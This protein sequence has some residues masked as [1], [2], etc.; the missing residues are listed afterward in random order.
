[1]VRGC[2]HSFYVVFW[3]SRCLDCR[4]VVIWIC[5]LCEKYRTL[6]N[7]DL[8]WASRWAEVSKIGFWRPS[9]TD[10][11]PYMLPILTFDFLASRG[12]RSSLGSLLA[13]LGGVD[14]CILQHLV[15]PCA[16]DHCI[17]QHLVDPSALDHCILQHLV[18]PSLRASHLLLRLSLSVGDP[19]RWFVGVDVRFTS[20]SGGR[21]VST[22]EL[23]SCGFCSVQPS[24]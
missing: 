13:W 8:P 3:R 5:P 18:D 4:T 6:S 22:V 14:H 9:K 12:S 20:C 21:G 7:L 10:T 17:L 24:W 1:M 11:I 23:S 2:R 19:L 15:D 16:L